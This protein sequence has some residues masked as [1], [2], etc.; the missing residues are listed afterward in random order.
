MSCESTVAHMPPVVAVAHHP[1]Q[2]AAQKT[3]KAAKLQPTLV[4]CRAALVDYLPLSTMMFSPDYRV[5]QL[6]HSKL[7]E[8]L[9]SVR[10]MHK[11]V[12]L[13]LKAQQ[14]RPHTPSHVT[15]HN[16]APAA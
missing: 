1:P 12:Q 6:Q 16:P 3:N 8:S 11:A 14:L 13:N 7:A 2:R 15:P 10:N 5:D 9:A 4:S